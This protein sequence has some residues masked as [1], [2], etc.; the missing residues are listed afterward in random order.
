MTRVLPL[1]AV[2]L[3]YR[4][5]TNARPHNEFEHPFIFTLVH[6]TAANT[7]VPSSV[8]S[9]VTAVVLNWAPPSRW[10]SCVLVENHQ[11]VLRVSSPWPHV[12]TVTFSSGGQVIVR[13]EDDETWIQ[14]LLNLAFSGSWNARV[15]R[16]LVRDYYI[17]Y[18]VPQLC[19]DRDAWRGK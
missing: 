19:T 5:V 7:T 17:E 6:A 11:E 1:T 8:A 3:C 2:C 16:H 9:A 10:N 14:R 18:I 4:K 15:P 12:V 13:Q